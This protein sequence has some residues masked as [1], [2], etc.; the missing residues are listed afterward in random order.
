MVYAHIKELLRVLKPSGTFILN[1]KEK[2]VNGE[3]KYL[4]NGINSG[5][6]KT[7]LVMD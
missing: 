4:R 2:V 3:N 6:E 1:I 5:N 7:G